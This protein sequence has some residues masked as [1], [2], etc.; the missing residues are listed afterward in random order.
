MKILVTGAAGFV[1]SHVCDSLLARGDE[2]I[3]IDNF[4]DYYEP[5]V[6]DQ[7]LNYFVQTLPIFLKWKKFFQEKDQIK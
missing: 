5:Q 2:V 6:K 4:N 3:A 7:N 1:G